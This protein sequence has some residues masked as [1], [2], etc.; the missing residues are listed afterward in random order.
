[1]NE[2]AMGLFRCC[3]IGCTAAVHCCCVLTGRLAHPARL[4]LRLTSSQ[5]T[6]ATVCRLPLLQIEEPDLEA[7]EEDGED[8][9][10]NW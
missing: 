1:M 5:P 6:C 10:A 2:P 3:W 4:R 8:D 7:D 9:R